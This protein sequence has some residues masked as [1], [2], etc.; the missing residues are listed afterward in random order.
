[1][2]HFTV[3]FLRKK[4]SKNYR[5]NKLNI[6]TEQREDLGN[7]TLFLLPSQRT[8]GKFH[9]INAFTRLMFFIQWEK[10]FSLVRIVYEHFYVFLLRRRVILTSRGQ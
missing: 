7:K 8:H 5:K 1:M 3:S 9:K 10:L 6:F 4:A 2:K